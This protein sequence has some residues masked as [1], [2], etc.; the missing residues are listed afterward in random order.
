[1]LITHRQGAYYISTGVDIE[2]EE[3]QLLEQTLEKICRSEM[4]EEKS[5]CHKT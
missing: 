2:E 1:V 5:A 4:Q 3:L